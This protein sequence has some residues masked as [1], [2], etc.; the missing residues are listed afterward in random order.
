MW[1]VGGRRFKID[2]FAESAYRSLEYDAI[3]C[4][5]VML[6]A[7]TAVTCLARGRRVFFVRTPEEARALAGTLEDPILAHED[8]GKGH[9]G[10]LHGFEL[11]AG[12]AAF[13]DRADV[14]RPLV[15]VSTLA[16]LL[17]NS[18]GASAVYVACLRNLSAMIRHL[19]VR[20]ERVALIS[21]GYAGELRCEDQ[22]VAGTIGRAL[23]KSGFQIEDMNTRLEVE[24]WG[25]ADPSVISLGKAADYLR[26]LGQQR[27]LDYV[28]GHVDDLQTIGRYVAGELKVAGL[29][30]RPAAFASVGRA[31]AEQVV[32]TMRRAGND[33]RVAGREVKIC[34]PDVP[35]EPTA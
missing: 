33:A 24:R 10:D 13:G 19:C 31:S 32:S 5:D 27:D 30:R 29:L 9:N 7:T 20:H 21:T 34:L 22:L 17:A 1:G 12:P 8:S 3:V 18:Q 25:E 11:S 14:R 6:A 26:R 35:L 15:L 28:L 16:H 4:I 2:A 23:R